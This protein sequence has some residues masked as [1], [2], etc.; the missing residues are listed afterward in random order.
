MGI[1]MKRKYF[2]GIIFVMIFMLSMGAITA[3]T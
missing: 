3:S 2:M 1:K